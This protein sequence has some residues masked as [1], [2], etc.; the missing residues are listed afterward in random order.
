MK[1]ERVETLVARNE[2]VTF[3][4]L[5]RPD[6]GNRKYASLKPRSISSH[7][8]YIM[9]FNEIFNKALHR[10]VHLPPPPKK[11]NTFFNTLKDN[12]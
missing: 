10:K 3:V 7:N 11:R 2:R 12:R 6:E 5:S 9:I 4:R 1:N 8:I